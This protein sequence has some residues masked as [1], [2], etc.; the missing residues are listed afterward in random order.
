M[1][2]TI[3]IG[4]VEV[5]MEASGD[6]PRM[7]RNI[8]GSDLIVG[9]QAFESRAKKGQTDLNASEVEMFENMAWCFAKHA[10]P[11][12]QDID[13]WLK[14]FEPMDILFATPKLLQIWGY[15]NKSTS[16][17]KKKNDK[18]TVK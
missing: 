8:F 2:E 1:K 9:M 3:K 15:D 4:N 16:K 5:L 12:I 6:I 17:L 7:Y 18:S 14:Q 13:E 10:D 11:D